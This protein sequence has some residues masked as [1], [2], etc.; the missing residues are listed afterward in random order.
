MLGWE[1]SSPNSSSHQS[2]TQLMS[3]TL[4]KV[5]TVLKQFSRETLSQVISTLVLGV[6]FVAIEILGGIIYMGPEEVRFHT[7]VLGPAGDLLI[8]SKAEGC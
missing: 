8:H 4:I 5:T 1:V 6:D 3:P 2:M 7:P